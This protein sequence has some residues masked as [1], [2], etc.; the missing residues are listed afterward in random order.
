ME[1]RGR[2]LVKIESARDAFSGI[3]AAIPVSGTVPTVIEA[4]GLHSER[5]RANQHPGRV[6]NG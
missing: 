5:K 4:C 3:V 6:V 2:Q 1:G